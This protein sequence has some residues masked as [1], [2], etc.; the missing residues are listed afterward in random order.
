[1][2]KLIHMKS[3]HGE[4]YCGSD[5]V[6]NCTARTND[7]TCRDCL[8]IYNKDRKKPADMPPGFEYDD[9]THTYTLDGEVIPSV[10]T[11]IADPVMLSDMKFTNVFVNKGNIGTRVHAL[12]EDINKGDSPD[13]DKEPERIRNYTLGYKKFLRETGFK[14][15]GIEQKVF[16]R[17]LGYA[18]TFDISGIMPDL[19]GDTMIT[20][21]LKTTY[22]LSPTVRLQMAAYANAYME[23]YPENIANADDYKLRLTIQLKDKEGGD[24]VLEWYTAQEYALDLAVFKAKL[25]SAK[26][27]MK[28]KIGMFK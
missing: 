22:K 25:V 1:M 16:S 14:P 23:M 4:V 2:S 7:V 15:L 24:Y 26:F 6:L 8:R 17:R 9:A 3:G 11:V 18:G 21:D 19:H 28:H 20:C 13:L 10:T 12:C 5:D 27:D